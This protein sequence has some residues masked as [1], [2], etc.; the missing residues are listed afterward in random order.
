MFETTVAPLTKVIPISF[1]YCI[2]EFSSFIFSFRASLIYLV[3]TFPV[4]NK[5]SAS[6]LV[7]N[8]KSISSGLI[9]LTGMLS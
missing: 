3:D 6:S 7:I 1:N 9:P 4:K 8:I 5:A 2:G